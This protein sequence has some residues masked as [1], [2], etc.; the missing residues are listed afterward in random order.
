MRDDDI[1]DDDIREHI[2][3]HTLTGGFCSS[4]S[5]ASTTSW[6]LITVMECNILNIC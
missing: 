5:V 6:E 1:R 3:I 2:H 4:E